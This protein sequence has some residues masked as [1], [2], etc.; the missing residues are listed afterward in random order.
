M[1]NVFI[2]KE[3]FLQL[4]NKEKTLFEIKE[5]KAAFHYK[6]NPWAGHE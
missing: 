5:A 4:L 3:G 2:K 1:F 6:Q